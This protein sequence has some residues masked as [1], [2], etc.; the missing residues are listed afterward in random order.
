MSRSR[1][2]RRARVR[3]A[4]RAAARA[5]SHVRRASRFVE[6]RVRAR[7]VGDEYHQSSRG[8]AQS[9]VGA[10]D[11]GDERGLEVHVKRGVDENQVHDKG[12][13]HDEAGRRGDAVHRRARRLA[14]ARGARRARAGECGGDARRGGAAG[15]RDGE[16]ER[17]TTARRRLAFEPWTTISLLF[18]LQSN[19]RARA[20][21]AP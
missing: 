12:A 1:F 13:E 7:A 10:L 11:A 18:L 4:P 20:L 6:H 14:A 8:R 5:T 21:A 17:T 3:D 15:R 2:R 19:R 9:R 16:R